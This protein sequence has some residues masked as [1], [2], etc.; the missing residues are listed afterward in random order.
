MKG[1]GSIRK[2]MTVHPLNAQRFR[3]WRQ[4]RA[5]RL[6]SRPCERSS[7]TGNTAKPIGDRLCGKAMST[8]EITPISQSSIT[9]IS[10]IAA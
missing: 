6:S 1:D 8:I 2:P 7:E 9:N 5:R 10:P 3:D 4:R